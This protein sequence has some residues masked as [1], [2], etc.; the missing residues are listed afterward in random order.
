[1]DNGDFKATTNANAGGPVMM[2]SGG[3]RPEG[4]RSVFVGNL[5][6]SATEEDLKWLFSD[7]GDIEAARIATDRETGRPRGFG[8]VD[9]A[10]EDCVDKAMAK[11]GTDLYGRAVRLDYGKGS[12]NNNGGG[13][14]GFGGG[15]GGRGGFG[16]D[17]G[18]RGGFGGGRG[19]FGGGFGGDRGGRGG[20]GGGRGGR[21]GFANSAMQ[22][23]KG[24]IAGFEGKKMTFDDDE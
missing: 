16:G 8:Y 21:G 9:F 7:C 24:S 1:M 12:N 14:G 18:G 15:Y 17:R 13:R 20:F 22:K 5:P 4:C 2:H 3:A 6:F 10:T 19:G 23:N 11:Q